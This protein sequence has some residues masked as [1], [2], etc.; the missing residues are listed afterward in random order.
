MRKANFCYFLYQTIL[1]A[2]WSCWIANLL[3]DG[4]SFQE[5]AIAAAFWFFGIGL[6][7]YP[8]GWIADRFGRKLSTMLGIA[9]LSVGFF[10]VG[11]GDS[12][13][14][15][16]SALGLSG[17]S[18]T[19]VS[20]A[21][22]SW[23]YN[24]ETDRDAKFDT[25]S[26]WI[27]MQ[28]LGR[29]GIIVGGFGGVALLVIDP[30]FVWYASSAIG[31]GLVFIMSGLPKGSQDEKCQTE[32]TERG[33]NSLPSAVWIILLSSA[34]FGIESGIRNL[35]YQPFLLELTDG[36]LIH[37]AYFQAILATV[38][39]LGLL[40]YRYGLKHLKRGPLLALFAGLAF[41][42][43]E[44]VASLGVSYETFLVAYAI[45]VFCLS[46]FFPVRLD[47]LNRNIPEAGRARVLSLDSTLE[48]AVQG[49]VCVTLAYST[50]SSF[51]SLWAIA[52]AGMVVCS[53]LVYFS[54][55]VSVSGNVYE[56]H[57]IGRPTADEL[58]A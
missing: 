31:L 42:G 9:G 16:W 40:V 21:F 5:A 33:G 52:A 18:V 24:R 44:L 32:T 47:M 1:G 17:L 10:V 28:I 36:D 50:P 15:Q 19:L 7:E 57:Q 45:G 41:A 4:M 49:I 25:E 54:K 29:L 35:I 53:G 39:L 56:G 55:Y 43:G 12:N 2:F 38:R 3:S 37:L 26:F 34:F 11:L 46:W 48:M 22:D 6:F 30:D 14:V 13:I 23:L 58:Q 20:G 8:T 27:R 51:S